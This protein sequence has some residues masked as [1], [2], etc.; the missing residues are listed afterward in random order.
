VSTGDIF[1]LS[2]WQAA[3]ALLNVEAHSQTWFA[4]EVVE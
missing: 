2:A 4:I 1:E 3:G